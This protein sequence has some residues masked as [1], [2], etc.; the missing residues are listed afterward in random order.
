MLLANQA[1]I[2]TRLHTSK[3]VQYTVHFPTLVGGKL[4]CGFWFF[5]CFQMHNVDYSNNFMN[6]CKHST[7]EQNDG[8]AKV[9]ITIRTCRSPYGPRTTA[10]SA[11]WM[12]WSWG[13]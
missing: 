13:F 5:V 6:L 11:P 8:T 1:S 4:F 12:D 10:P 2:I 3:T 9:G 7:P